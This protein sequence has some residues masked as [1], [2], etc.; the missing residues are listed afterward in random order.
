MPSV[1]ILGSADL[2]K[3]RDYREVNGLKSKEKIMAYA[4]VGKRTQAL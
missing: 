1:V 4:L 2:C 3:G